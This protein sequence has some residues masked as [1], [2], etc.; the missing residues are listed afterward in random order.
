MPPLEPIRI[1]PSE[2]FKEAT[3]NEIKR[4]EQAHIDA[5]RVPNHILHRQ[6]LSLVSDA[7]NALYKEG[8]I[9]VGMTVNDKY[10][11]TQI[12]TDNGN[13]R[14]ENSDSCGGE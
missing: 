11:T 1:V 12:N 6:F 14:T 10:I 4:F 5:H 2:A 3:L 8:R 13:K 9:R 7:L